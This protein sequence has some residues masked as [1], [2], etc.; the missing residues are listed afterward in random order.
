MSYD[1]GQEVDGCAWRARGTLTSRLWEEPVLSRRGE[2]GQVDRV[3]G[4]H[5]SQ[6]RS[7]LDLC[8]GNMKVKYNLLHLFT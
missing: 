8:F 7:K 4:L 3:Q 2:A 6:M 5:L 1:K